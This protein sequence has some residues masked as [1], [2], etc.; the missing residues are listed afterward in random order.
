MEHCI[1]DIKMAAPGEATTMST[2][3]CPAQAKVEVSSDRL[4]VTLGADPSLTQGITPANLLAQL[5]EMGI[6]LSE[7]DS[8]EALADADGQIRSTEDIVLI[9]GTPPIPEQP[10]KQELLV[11]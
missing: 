2:T 8:I 3:D 11:K 7:P 10:A 9:R 5:H 1:S 4:T 6:E